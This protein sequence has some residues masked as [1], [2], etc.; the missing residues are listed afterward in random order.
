MSVVRPVQLNNNGH[1]LLL[2]LDGLHLAELHL[3]GGQLA[4]HA[5]EV[6]ARA[7]VVGHGEGDVVGLAGLQ[8]LHAGRD[9]LLVREDQRLDHD[10]VPQLVLD[11]HAHL[12]LFG[13]KIV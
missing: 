10:V 6:A 8:L 9:L 4:L 5:Q 3:A 11:G 12:H 1:G 2:E 7:N 13:N